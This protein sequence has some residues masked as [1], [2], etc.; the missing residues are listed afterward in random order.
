MVVE[1]GQ[2]FAS[3]AR[4]ACP[5]EGQAD[6]R[7]RGGRDESLDELG[8]QRLGEARIGHRGRQAQRRQF[9]R[10]REAFAET[11]AERQQRKTA[12]ISFFL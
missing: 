4:S 6:L 8:V 2:V 11:S 7:G 12:R 3:A 10:S 5:R 9:V 1:E